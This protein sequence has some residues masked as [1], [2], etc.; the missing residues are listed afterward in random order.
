[1]R[2]AAPRPVS[3][4]PA[5][6]SD[7]LLDEGVMPITVAAAAEGLTISAKTALR[8]AITGSRG[9]RLATI[10]VGGRRLTSRAAVRRF[11]AAQ[12]HDA[13][14]AAQTLDARAADAVLAAHGLP[15]G[16]RSK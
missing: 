3:A 15:R 16:G 8:W 1:M 11:V 2:S 4:P 5:S 9:V 13:P 6:V 7:A 14:P 10:K 12:Q